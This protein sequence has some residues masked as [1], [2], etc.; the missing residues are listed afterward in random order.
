L[1]LTYLGARIRELLARLVGRAPPPRPGYFIPGRR[2]SVRGWLHAAPW[3]WPAREYLLY[4]PRRHGGWRR[5]PLVVLIHGC[6][7]T[8]EDFAAATRIAETADQ[9]GWLVLL[10]RQSDKANPWSCWNWFDA[11]TAAGRGEAAIVKAQV[12]GI[13]RAYRIHPRRIFVAGFSSGG[14]LAAALAL[15]HPELFAGVFVHSG[16]ACGAAEKPADAL[17]VMRKGAS[18]DVDAIGA[19]ARADAPGGAVRLPLL[20]VHGTADDV[21]AEVNAAQ[22]VGQFLALNG[23]GATPG[24][25]ALPQPDAE[26][27]LPLREGRTISIAD[28]RHGKRLAARLVRVHDLGHAW[29]GGDRAFAYN[30]P[31]PPDA[32]SLLAEFVEGRMRP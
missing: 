23:R 8:P 21:V 9:Y 13:R 10:P 15:R 14:C 31:D 29:S 4:V 30:D 6:R 28:F 5:A 26:T 22:L 1:N 16:V 20:V 32:T 24:A 11:A 18:V 25:G 27:T 2:F 17:A 7:Q 12:R 19:R 3:L